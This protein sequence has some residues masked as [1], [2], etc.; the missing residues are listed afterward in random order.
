MRCVLVLLL[1]LSI[2][3]PAIA[4]V[5]PAHAKAGREISIT[6]SVSPSS[7]FTSTMSFP[8]ENHFARQ[9]IR[10]RTIHAK[11]HPHWIRALLTVKRRTFVYDHD[12]RLF[13]KEKPKQYLLSKNVKQRLDELVQTVEKVHFGQALHWKQVKKSFG[14]MDYAT[15][16][17]L[18]TG[19]RF[20]VQRRAGSRHADVQPLTRNDTLIMKKIYQ[21]KWSWKRRAILV[22]VDES[23]YAASMHGMPHGAGAIAGNDFPGHFCIHFFGSSTHLR[24][25]P[26]PSHSLMILKASGALPKTLM[27]AEP[28]Q[29]VSYFLTSLH[30]H[31]DHTLKMTTDGSPLPDDLAM[32]DSVKPTDAITPSKDWGPVIAEVPVRVDYFT[33]NGSERKGRWTFLLGRSAPWE[34]WRIVSVEMND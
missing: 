18:E 16:V 3:F 10:A 21:G 28:E 34:R 30:E 11:A 26:D 13:D 5:H 7:S 17:D 15:V 4:A 12:G 1:C 2:I 33:K 6:V 9:L 29:L 20:Q 31:D 22:K 25:E 8:D 32:I 19:E 27:E 24:K 14:R 23:Y